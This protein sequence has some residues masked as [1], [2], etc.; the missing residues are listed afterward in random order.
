MKTFQKKILSLTLLLFSS[1]LLIS[2]KNKPKEPNNQEGI[3]CLISYVKR[4]NY[5]TIDNKVQG[6]SLRIKMSSGEWM[7]IK[8]MLRATGSG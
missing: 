6:K 1:F 8:Y 4:F 3:N 5:K 7:S 2:C